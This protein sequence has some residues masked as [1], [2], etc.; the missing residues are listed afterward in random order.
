MNNRK[1]KSFTIKKLDQTDVTSFEGYLSTYG[2]ADRVGDVIQRGAFDKSIKKKPVVPMLFNHNRDVVIGKLELSSDS[3]GLKVKGTILNDTKDG[4]QVAG[5]IEFGALDSMSVGMRVLS[6]E[7]VD[8]KDPWGG[9]IIKEAEVL[10][11]SVVTIPANEQATIG[12]KVPEVAASLKSEQTKTKKGEEK[13]MTSKEIKSTVKEAIN[14]EFNLSAKST[15]SY[16]S[17]KLNDYLSSKKSVE[18]FTKIAVKSNSEENLKNAW[19]EHLK[20]KGLSFSSE[21]SNFPTAI[22]SAFASIF[23]TEGTIMNTFRFEENI[24]KFIQYI[25]KNGING[26]MSGEPGESSVT[27][28]VKNIK[29]RYIGKLVEISREMFKET[30][31]MV[32]YVTETIPMQIRQGIERAAIISDG[33]SDTDANKINSF[34]AIAEDEPDFTGTILTSAEMN[35]YH[36][37]LD[38]S[39]L[40]KQEGVQYLVTSTELY[41][42]AKKNYTGDSIQSETGKAIGEFRAI[43]PEWMPDPQNA[44]V[45]DPLA[46]LYV[47]K[48]YTYIG[49]KETEYMNKFILSK[50]DEEILSDIFA[51]GALTKYHS[52]AVLK[53][54]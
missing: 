41:A 5:L 46:V 35:Y 49:D 39:A 47:D 19:A 13:T 54:A 27:F 23:E 48:A 8:E 29:A 10:E 51:G 50:N 3:Y 4:E 45:G 28:G 32:S 17:K 26:V 33:R 20:S 2:N 52:A 34:L 16:F 36:A 38:M 14:E 30:S 1:E 15:E 21:S 6:Y 25:D 22:Y 11:G 18:A 7:P 40:I 37:F 24:S 12:E 31:S 43:T 9:W 53:K 44:K 42:E